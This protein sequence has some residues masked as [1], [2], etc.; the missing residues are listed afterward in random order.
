MPS[1]NPADKTEQK[2]RFPHEIMVQNATQISPRI[3]PVC[4]GAHIPNFMEEGV[5]HRLGSYTVSH[6]H[7]KNWQSREQKSASGHSGIFQ[8]A[9]QRAAAGG[10]KKCREEHG[11]TG[12]G[13]NTMNNNGQTDGEKKQ[14]A[15]A[16]TAKGRAAQHKPER[17]KISV[18]DARHRISMRGS[19]ECAEGPIDG[20]AHAQAEQSGQAGAFDQPAP[21]HIISRQ[22]QP[23]TQGSGTKNGRH[24][25]VA[26]FQKSS[27]QGQ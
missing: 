9:C 10:Q 13:A 18:I 4:Q 17:K 23:N 14:G 27:Q 15:Q 8:M 26:P 3:A 16:W 5:M 19:P 1:N 24:R 6:G 21:Q 7:G 22:M 12:Q 2:K 20:H 25:P 11:G